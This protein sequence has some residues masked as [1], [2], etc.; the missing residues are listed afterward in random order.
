MKRPMAKSM[1]LLHKF[2]SIII[3]IKRVREVA[4]EASRISGLVKMI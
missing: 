3:V 4:I 2:P 1:M